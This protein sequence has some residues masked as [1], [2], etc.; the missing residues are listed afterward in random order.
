MHT[1]R[2]TH[3]YVW[4]FLIKS[5]EPHTD[6]TVATGPDVPQHRHGL[7]VEALPNCKLAR[8]LSK[9]MI[10]LPRDTQFNV[11]RH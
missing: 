10:I 6:S 9:M 5:R 2:Y 4:M 1:T 3:F 8:Q 7:G 11:S